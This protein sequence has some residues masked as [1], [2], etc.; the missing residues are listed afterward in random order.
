M[1]R[2][3]G[4]R[5]RLVIIAGIV[6]IAFAGCS[7]DR[8]PLGDLTSGAG[9]PQPAPVEMNGRWLLA[10]PGTPACGMAFSGSRSEGAIAPEGGCPG[11]F[12]TSRRWAFEGGALLIRDHN[13]EL[14]GRLALAGSRFEGAA[15]DG[16]QI[17]LTR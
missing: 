4:M 6:A 10:A 13:G 7:G 8:S 14:L 5:A 2:R 16:K 17:T 11:N 15:T 12:F 3:D 9:A 1:R